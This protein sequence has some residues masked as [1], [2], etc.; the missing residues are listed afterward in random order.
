MVKFHKVLGLL[1][2]GL[3]LTSALTATENNAS[4]RRIIAFKGTMTPSER[5][6]IIETSGGKVVRDLWLI[7][8]VAVEYP[9]AQAQAIEAQLKTQSEVIRI[10]NDFRQKWIEN[11]PAFEV[12]ALQSIIKPM[13]APTPIAPPQKPKLPWGISKV[14]APAA[15]A[16][17]RGE[18]VKVVVIDTG[19]D[20]D[21]PGLKGNLKGGWNA[22]T[23]TDDYKDDHGHGTHCSG[24]IAGNGALI[25]GV[26]IFGVAPK[27]DLYGV[28]VLDANGSGTFEDV[29]AGMQW[30]VEHHMDV[31]SMSLGADQGNDSLKAAVEAMAANGVVL[32]AAAGNSGPS[33][34]TVGYPAGY[35]GAVAI[36]ASDVNNKVA[37]FSSR[38]KQVALIAPGVN[39][40]SLV[41]GGEAGTMSGTSM[42]TPHVAGLA[43]LAI[44]GKDVHGYTNVRKALLDA[45]TRFPR[46]P[47]EHQGAGLINAAKLVVK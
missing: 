14:N 42:A 27:V 1:A 39:V 8:A 30:A 47:T 43:A 17:T 22:V 18:G 31:A 24:T 37:S 36:A 44:A 9:W 6:K 21:H 12:P 41:L 4:V 28:K 20:Y 35:E 40:L 29:I 46:V 5:L 7:N 32:I 19:I 33:D 45:A 11:M 34:N 2:L 13:Q 25:K 26:E 3:F 23:K 10:D 16:V 38:G 15:W